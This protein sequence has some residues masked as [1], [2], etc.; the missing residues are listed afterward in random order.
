MLLDPDAFQVVDPRLPE[1]GSSPVPPSTRRTDRDGSLES[2]AMVVTR[3]LLRLGRG[4]RPLPLLRVVR[5]GVRILLLDEDGR[6]G[7]FMLEEDGRAGA[8]LL[9]LVVR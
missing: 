1:K 5:T 4:W 7:D 8:R 2:T 9:E 3:W 6:E